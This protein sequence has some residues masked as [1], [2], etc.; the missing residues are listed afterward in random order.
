M[1][2][3]GKTI[4]ISMNLIIRGKAKLKHHPQHKKDGK[5]VF[6]YIRRTKGS[7][8]AGKSF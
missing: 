8:A 5:L 4:E 3:I 7:M 1:N 6:E 2:N